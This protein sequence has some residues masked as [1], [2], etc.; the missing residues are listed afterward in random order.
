MDMDKLV[1]VDAQYREWISEVSKR[2]HQSQIKAAVKVNDEML[3]FY[4]QLGKELHDRK[5]KFSYGQSFYKTISR[6]LRRELPDVKSFSETN[7]RYMQKF[8]ELYSEI[9]NLPQVGEDFRSEEIEPLFA[10]P[11]GHHKII[12]DKCNGNPKKALFFVNQV[13]QNNWSRAVLLN[14]LDTDLYE[15]QG[16][17]ITNFNLT[18]P[19]MQSDLAQEITKDPYKFDFITLTQSY[20]EKELKDALMDNIQKFLLELGNGFAFVGREYRIEIGSTENFIDMLFYHI[21]LHCYVVVEVKVTEFESSYAG[22]LGTYVVAVNHQLKTEKDEPTL[23]LLV[24][25]S[26]DD[27]KAQYALEAS[28]QPLG[29]S[30]YELSKLIPEN[31]KGSLPS[32]DEIESELRKDTEG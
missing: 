26:K 22:Q 20:N 3:R 23:G 29:V 24:C 21:R 18:L 5:D 8:A 15:R 11:W 7:L 6:D 12:I 28:S 30:A 27:I 16:K 1:E 10:I 19:A 9:S 4:W 32:I 2:F 13:I 17:A 31:F 25:K 14:F